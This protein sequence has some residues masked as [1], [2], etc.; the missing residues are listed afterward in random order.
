[1]TLKYRP[2][3]FKDLIGQGRATAVLKVM[4]RTGVP[5]ALIFFGARG[6][7]KTTAARVL[8]AALNCTGRSADESE[9]CGHCAQC[10]GVWAANS[11]SVIEVDAASSGGVE[12]VRKLRDLTMYSHSG[13]YRVIMLDEVHS[14]SREAFNALL[15]TLEEPPPTARFVLL[16]TERNKIPETIR[17]RSMDFEFRRIPPE[18][19]IE[20]LHYVAACEHMSVEDDLLDEIARQ[21]KG[22]LRDAVM[23]LDQVR[24]IGISKGGDFRDWYGVADVGA[25]LVRVCLSGN[26]AAVVDCCSD[27]VGRTGDA[28]QLMS[29]ALEVLRDMV[30]IAAGGRPPCVAEQFEARAALTSDVDAGCVGKAMNVLWQASRQL[31]YEEDQILSAQVVAIIL[32]DTLRPQ[33]RPIP[34]LDRRTSEMTLDEMKGM[35]ASL[36]GG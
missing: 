29:E 2:R 22:G 28:V 19:I 21:A 23:L 32:A 35:V 1:L 8:S 13:K 15:K 12:D 34:E 10:E 25:E 24:S 18:G 16:T 7:G 4:V 14:A 5:P 11:S 31:R 17:S 27:A 30:V 36:K 33:R 3:M 20:R 6:T 9:P 26:L